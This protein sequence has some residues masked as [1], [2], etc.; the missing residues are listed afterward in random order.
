MK[1]SDIIN[2]L[3]S[4]ELTNTT[5]CRER[6]DFIIS[7]VLS[8]LHWLHHPIKKGTIIS[9]CRK[10]APDYC[11]DSYG[12]RKPEDVNGL[13]RASI[14]NE[15]VFYGAVGDRCIDDGDL[16]AMLETSKM[17]RNKML[18]GKEV[19]YVS[20]WIVTQ[21]IDMA[22]VCHPN[23]YVDSNAGGMVSEMQRN[24]LRLLPYYPCKDLIPEFDKLV[25]FI[26]KQFSKHVVSGE[27]YQY[28]ISALF[29]HYALE[30]EPGLIYPS[31]QVKGRLG[32]N[33]AIR[34]DVEKNYLL[35]LDADKHILYKT[36]N[37][38]QVQTG[39]AHIAKS[40]GIDSLDKLPLIE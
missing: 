29:S 7:L 38:L 23:V 40:L 16:I 17:H 20:H 39:E 28:L 15:S 26:A 18:I 12:S 13:Q 21:D 22:L 6:V 2:E 1:L 33:V 36:E 5:E 27:T 4:L 8:R 11:K 10:S 9:R 32:Y 31:T 37:Y 25:E 35:F 14:E 34:S 19:L 30:T 3:E 24:Y